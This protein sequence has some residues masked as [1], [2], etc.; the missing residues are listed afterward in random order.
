MTLGRV[1]NAVKLDKWPASYPSERQP[2]IFEVVVRE[3]HWR[4]V[5]HCIIPVFTCN[6]QDTKLFEAQIQ[7]GST[8]ES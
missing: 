8:A 4:S 1:K 6:R 3:L 5:R 7:L 2:H